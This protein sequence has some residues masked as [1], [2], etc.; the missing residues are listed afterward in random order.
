MRKLSSKRLFSILPSKDLN[1][2]HIIG[3]GISGISSAYYINKKFPGSQITIIDKNSNVAQETS[4]GN[5]GGLCH[6]YGI[7]DPAPLS[8]LTP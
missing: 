5:S 4:W 6:S 8:L 7:Y 3:S 2:I 1:S